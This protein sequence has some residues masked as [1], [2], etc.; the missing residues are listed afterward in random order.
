MPA[1]IELDISKAVELAGQGAS[2]REIALSLGC[3]ESVVRR[4]LRTEL[5]KARAEVRIRLRQRQFDAAESGNTTMLIW[6]G[7]Q[8]LGQCDKPEVQRSESRV[9][10][11]LP[12][13]Y[14]Q[15]EE[16]VEVDARA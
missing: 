2:N 10:V 5:A 1:K 6:L 3:D 9:V 7:K 4:R 8:Y 12:V 13:V 14:L 11:N 15:G 16:P